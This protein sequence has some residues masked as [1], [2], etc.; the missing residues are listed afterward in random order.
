MQVMSASPS[1]TGNVFSTAARG[2]VTH[3]FSGHFNENHNDFA[4]TPSTVHGSEQPAPIDPFKKLAQDLES[5]Y[6]VQQNLRLKKFL[7]Q[8][9]G[10]VYAVEAGR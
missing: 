9:P 6:Q 2:R 1:E 3:H 7:V 8:S 5:G 4:P 10:G